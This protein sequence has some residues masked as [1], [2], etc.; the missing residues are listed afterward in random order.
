MH[1]IRSFALVAACLAAAV[2]AMAAARATAADADNKA[3]VAEKEQ[4]LIGVLKSDAPPAEKAITCKQ[5]AVYGSKDAVPALAALLS[6]EKLASWSRIALEAIPDPAADDA[7]RVAVGKVQGRLLVGVINSIGVRRDAKSVDTLAAKLKDADADVASAAAVALGR[8]GGPAVAKALEPLLAS[9]PA[10]VRSA[11]AE[12]C[13]LCAERF[14]AAGSKDDAVKLYDAVRKADVPKQRILEGTRGAILA[15]QAA[16]VPLLVE[17]LRSTDKALFAIGLS[18]ARELPG[19]EV[20]DALVAEMAKAT[21]DRQAMLLL[22]MADRG[23]VKAIPAVLAAAKSGPVPVRI[24][25]VGVLA[26]LGNGSCVPVLLDASVD[27]DASLAQA[28]KG[29]LVKMPGQEVDAA[30][31]A[32]LPKASG[33][34]RQA[35]IE[36]AGARRTMAALPAILECASDADAGIRGAAVDALGSIADEKQIPDVVKVLEKTSDPKDR[37]AIEKAL[38]AISGRAG[39]AAVQPLKALA[40]NQDAGLRISALHALA[41]AG[42]PEAL[43]AVK[44]A[45]ED[46]DKAVQD[47]AVR[48]LSS[49]PNK[50][51]E[52]AGVAEPL[53]GLVKSSKDATRQVLAL[54]GYLQYVQVTKKLNDGEKLAKVNDVLP[55]MTRPEEKRIAISVLGTLGTAGALEA[56]STLAGDPAIAEEACSA[57]VNLAGKNLQGV[58]KEQ[59]QKA[60][61]TVLEKSKNDG[62][63]KRADETLKGIK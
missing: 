52:D 40:K 59:R 23:D 39:A 16:G 58:T 37:A 7:L 2:C 54:R 50:W 43:D 56:L 41:S 31:A 14:L 10:A 6:D 3:A 48:T 13:V 51:P 46:P 26:V 55:L 62:T 24:A 44:A 42:G 29:S 1:K 35:L 28:A 32:Q 45:I 15:R 18:A 36:V 33:K 57:L 30:I 22:A 63:K 61:Q 20:T 34:S 11:V 53:L 60:L 47:D 5:L 27:A 38:M 4:K 8:I 49:W 21:P 12:G 17:Q 25:A 19:P 9:A